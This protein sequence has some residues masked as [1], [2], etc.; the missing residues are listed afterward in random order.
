SER[1]EPKPVSD[2]GRS[3]LAAEREVRDGCQCD[4]T[5]IR[6]PAVYGP[7]DGEFL[8]L[9]KAVKSHLLPR[10]GGGRQ[11]L[12]LVYAEDLAAVVALALTHPRASREIFFAGSP[13]VVTAVE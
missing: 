5:I 2:Y 13:E 12:T 3:K 10:F 8:R 9:F 7:R 1:E 4:W 6:P 11:Q